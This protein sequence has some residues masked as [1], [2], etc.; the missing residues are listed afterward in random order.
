[1]VELLFKQIC[2]FIDRRYRGLRGLK[3]FVHQLKADHQGTVAVMYALAFIPTLAFI[4]LAID[5]GRIYLVKDAT[6]KSL[7]A[8]VLAAGHTL[9]A[10]NIETDA[11][12]FFSENMNSLASYAAISNTNVVT[13]DDD[14]V[15]TFT[16]SVTLNMT[17]MTLFGYDD[18]VLS[19]TTEV[20]SET[21]GLELV[22]VMDN[23]GSMGSGTKMDDAQDAASN[24]LQ[25]LY[26]DETTN[27]YLFIGVVP[28]IASANVGD[29]YT[30][31]LS[32]ASQV[33]LSNGD[34]GST[35]WKGCVMARAAPLDQND[36]P[37]TSDPFEIYLWEDQEFGSYDKN[38]WIRYSWWYGWYYD[39]DEGPS[40]STD[41][42]N[43][44]C[45][46][47]ILPLT[48]Q[49]I[50]VQAA[51]DDMEP[52]THGGTHAHYG[53]VWGWRVISPLWR[54][55]WGGA[56]PSDMPLDYDNDIMDKAIILLTDGQNTIYNNE[57]TVYGDRATFGYSSSSAAYAELDART[58][59]VCEA[60]KAEDIYLFTITFGTSIDS[61]T[62]SLMEG[63][64]S[65]T[66]YYFHAP[67]GNDLDDAFDT[68][69]RQLSN[70]RISG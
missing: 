47:P 15:I 44:G 67:D 48:D 59:T 50:D 38:D 19:A 41:G 21:R 43:L 24:L 20:T 68:I 4:G 22:I 65:S 34:F 54:G 37:P 16:A 64:A 55:L 51:I 36:T 52:W 14:K 60:V 12:M 56:T 58:S 30:N 57:K 61:G 29:Q 17:F 46:D 53:L 26:D 13:S 45:G 7:D 11:L 40:S 39:I 35:D 27:P 8:A 9:S 63:C 25:A 42:P 31:W 10:D 1:M 32:T 2:I 6:Q 23:T 66:S 3:W 62:Q 33:R 5:S 49:R 69:G 70:L 28:F 18:I